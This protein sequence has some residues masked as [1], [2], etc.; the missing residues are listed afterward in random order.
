MTD[1]LPVGPYRNLEI[2]PGVQA[3]W[4]IIPFDEQGYCTGPWTRNDLLKA[5]KN[6]TYTD[7]FLFSHGWNN[8]WAAASERYE[9]FLKGYT[10]M[11]H[12]RG[13]TYP[14]PFRP[15]LV[16]VFWP[17]VIL[18]LPGERSPAFAAL[19][20]SPARSMDV[21]VAQ[22]RQEIQALA[23]SIAPK[24]VERFYDLAQRTE[25]GQEEALELARMLSPIY[26]ADEADDIPPKGRA[27]TPKDV[28][29]LWHS[30]AAKKPLQANRG[31]GGFAQEPGVSPAKPPGDFGFAREPQDAPQGAGIFDLLD[32]RIIIRLAT[33]LQ[34][35]DRA[36]KVGARGVGSLLAELLTNSADA[37]IHLIGHSYG[38][39]VVL[40][41]L[42][43]Q[44][45]DRRVNSLLL[46]QPAV[47]YL[48]FAE[49]ATGTGQPG[50]YR[51]ALDRVEEPILTTFT[52]R[53]WPLSKFFHLAVRRSSDIGEIS[54]AG[55][56]PSRY[57]ALGGFGP[58]G[59]DA[60][61]RE[62]R[63]KDF[64][65]QYALGAGAPRIYALN[66]AEQISGHGDISN[67]ATWWAL[68]EQ[69]AQ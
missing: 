21:E 32:P 1:K 40:S 61:C 63:M 58:G 49:D 27:A 59:C 48:C 55:A 3:P 36:G 9:H 29:K 39:K 44:P 2:E 26:S 50:G 34:M 62:I 64:G 13:L 57:A 66:A 46:L 16:G 25:L 31:Q 8:D 43:F 23:S 14:R 67:L 6:G 22:E 54:M 68:Y 47:S 17:S 11:R 10:E 69:V 19:P 65:D 15:L 53:D 51:S 24:N 42:C 52:P 38:C 18:V 45:L 33:V 37:R 35:K 5:V 30:V 28:V 12:T 56:P 20:A 4:Y 60:D 41:A 7:I